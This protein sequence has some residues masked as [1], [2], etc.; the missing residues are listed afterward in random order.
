MG[1]F[2]AELEKAG[3]AASN[4][5]DAVR[6]IAEGFLVLGSRATSQVPL[7]AFEFLVKAVR[8]GRLEGPRRIMD[9]HRALMRRL[10]AEA[11]VDD[12]DTAAADLHRSLVGAL[13][14]LEISG[15]DPEPVIERIMG[16]VG[17]PDA[18]L[19]AT[20][21]TTTASSRSG[22]RRADGPDPKKPHREPA[23]KSSRR[24]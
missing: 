18:A 20:R 4:P 6:A 24:S 12:P 9:A 23:P 19:T 2:V 14:H 7:V 17:L 1:G 3:A 21:H 22:S 16:L 13:I 15:S 8:N 10:L 5:A 11:G